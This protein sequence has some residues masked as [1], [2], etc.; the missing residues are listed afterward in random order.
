MAD[1]FGRGYSDTPADMAQDARLFITQIL[2]VIS[3]SSLPWTGHPGFNLVGFSLGG[4]VSI[5]FT[6]Y[7]PHLVQSLTLIASGGLIRPHHI[8]W[9]SKVLYSRGFLPE[10]LLEY[11]VKRRLQP[12]VSSPSPPGPVIVKDTDEAVGE[13]VPN[14]DERDPKKDSDAT[15][16]ENFDKA[17]LSKRFPHISVASIVSWQIANHAGFIPAFISS[18][19]YAPIYNQHAVWAIIGARLSEQKAN[20]DDEE[21]AKRGL[22]RSKVLMIFGATDPIV[23][24]DEVSKDAKAVLG[25]GNVEIVVIES[26]HELPIA[27]SAEVAEV[28]WNFWREE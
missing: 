18:I 14:G 19:R 7:L 27:K 15:G 2:L 17:V 8:G 9:R 5:S 10:S 13:K 16:G 22:H 23:L 28:M 12:Q 11:L 20:P 21:S 1:L 26:G 24:V 25:D 4:G 3:S 6:R